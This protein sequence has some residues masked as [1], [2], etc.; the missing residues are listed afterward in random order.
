MP[1][2]RHNKKTNN[3]SKK[4]SK[5]ILK[6]LVKGG[7]YNDTFLENYE[8]NLKKTQTA[9]SKY[10]GKHEIH[11]KQ[12]KKFIE[13]QLTDARKQ[14]AHDLVENA[15]YISFEE[16]SKTVEH[17]IKKS[18]ANFNADAD[19]YLYTGPKGK[20]FY[21]LSILAL[22]YIRK[23]GL[24]EPTKFISGFN[25]EIFDEIGDSPI[26]LLDDVAYSGSQLSELL[27]NIYYDTVV[28]NKKSPPNIFILLVA[29]NTFSKI[30]LSRVPTK[31]KSFMGTEVVLEWGVSPFHL[32]Y[33]TKKLFRPLILT[34]GIQRYFNINIL[35]SPYTMS[36]PYIALYL[37]YKIADEVSTYKNVLFYGPIVPE[38]YDYKT[39]IV[40]EL[41][42]QY[43][44]FPSQELFDKD[45]YDKLFT[46]FNKEYG[47]EF[48]KNDY[49]LTQKLLEN[50]ILSD[51]IISGSKFY[52]LVSTCNENEDLLEI[53]KDE[54]VQNFDYR[55]FVAPKGCI[56][57]NSDCATSDD[58][59]L[60]YLKSVIENKS[61][62][63]GKVVNIS[64]KINGYN[65]PVTW[66]KKG[67]LKLE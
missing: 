65:C 44:I 36:T 12:S 62:D 9:I 57:G 1:T 29:L 17:L 55:L 25:E 26:I 61:L 41:D 37:D 21:F 6:H 43:N 22:F 46:D 63:K 49:R 42:Y 50:L 28:M 48:K 11:I 30:K 34:L 56:E 66:Y 7:G 15:I 13:N 60:H 10:S 54:D 39:Y 24:K 64:N 20:S 67:D 4:N 19:I 59:V 45:D 2:K 33:S 40:D 18:Y 38:D 14:A 35:F 23:N 31:K 3:R 52:P 58:G 51:K 53:L 5:S 8:E 27:N 47:T 32:I 16:L